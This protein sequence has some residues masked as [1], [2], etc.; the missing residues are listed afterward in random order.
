MSRF[1]VD[2]VVGWRKFKQDQFESL[3]VNAAE[4]TLD[5]EWLSDRYLTRSDVSEKLEK[6]RRCLDTIEAQSVEDSSGR[7]SLQILRGN[8]CKVGSVCPACSS[9]VQSRRLAVYSP[10]IKSACKEY[11]YR[12]LVTFTI[13]DGPVLSERLDHLRASFRAWLRLGQLRKNGLRSGGE[14]RKITGALVGFETTKT[15]GGYHVHAH[16]LIF[17]YDRLDYEIYDQKARALVSGRSGGRASDADLA[18][19]VNEWIWLDGAPVPVSKLSRE[20]FAVTGDSVNVECDP[21]GGDWFSVEKSA[22]EVL[23][24]AVKLGASG[25][26]SARDYIEIVA[27]TYGRRMFSALGIFRGLL[28]GRTEFDESARADYSLVWDDKTGQYWPGR[29][30]RRYD[31]AGDALRVCGVLVGQWRRDRRALCA[32]GPVPGLA[33]R[34]DSLKRSYRE[35]IKNIWRS[36]NRDAFIESLRKIPVLPSPALPVW[37]QTSL[38]ST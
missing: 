7:E 9:R 6:V 24:Y 15:G 16:A 14:S 20:W 8:W 17:C 21:L 34:L 11:R 19:C 3:G 26:Y 13:K 1:T 18:A 25:N 12:Y 37:V 35:V 36:A 28:N 23:K 5:P 29:Y 38:F 33:G 27:G 32:S 4:K 10:H 30:A 31:M 22:H 2:R